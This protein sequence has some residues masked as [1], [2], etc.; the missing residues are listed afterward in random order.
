MGVESFEDS[1]ARTMSL[2]SNEKTF[3]DKLT[4]KEDVL[5]MRELHKQLKNDRKEIMEMLQLMVGNE[6]KLLNF[7]EPERHIFAR[8]TIRISEAF[9]LAEKVWDVY[10]LVSEKYGGELGD[11]EVMQVWNQNIEQVNRTCKFFVDNFQWLTRSGMS[12]G[13]VGFEKILKNRFEI[14]YEKPPGQEKKG[15]WSGI[16]GGKS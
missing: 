5:R 8:Y 4:A 13:G 12:I 10:D 1:L 7:D 2:Y 9:Q 6:A 15:F 14:S 11:N 3:I 16:L